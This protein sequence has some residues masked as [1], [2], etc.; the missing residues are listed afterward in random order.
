MGAVSDDGAWGCD[1]IGGGAL[2]LIR[3]LGRR[4]VLA[5]QLCCHCHCHQSILTPPQLTCCCCCRTW[6]T[7]EGSICQERPLHRLLL[8]LLL[9]L[10]NPQVF[11]RQAI[12]AEI[13]EVFISGNSYLPSSLGLGIRSDRFQKSEQW[14]IFSQLTS[15]CGVPIWQ[16][17]HEHTSILGVSFISETLKWRN[18]NTILVF[19]YLLANEWIM[20]YVFGVFL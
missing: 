5:Q 7:W 15:F 10:L 1:L 16:H 17:L 3:I 19:V 18:I 12:L 20:L 2:W 11:S 8:L 13:R 4:P 14:L 6:S 9:L